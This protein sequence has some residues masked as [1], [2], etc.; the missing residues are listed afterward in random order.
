MG[1]R[2]AL[3]VL[4]LGS[5]RVSRIALLDTGTH[6]VGQNEVATRQELL[7]VSA[8]LG[9]QALADRWLPPMVK[10]GLLDRDPVLRSKLFAMVLRMTPAIHR[11][12]IQAL[13]TRPDARTQLS[14]IRCPV[15]IGVGA[16]DRWSPPAQHA[17]IA[18]A[19][20]NARYVIFAGSGHMAPLETPELVT[21]ALAEWMRV[22]TN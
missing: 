1:A 13:L 2:V 17:E 16:E 20:A 10:N 5:D 7:D 3:E 18:A 8:N 9:M 6:P 12:Q 11:N 4:T 19:V 22:T 15:L 21:A 14:A